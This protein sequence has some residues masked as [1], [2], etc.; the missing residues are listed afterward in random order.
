MFLSST[1]PVADAPR[2]TGCHRPM[3]PCF[4]A[5]GGMTVNAWYCR[6]CHCWEAAVGRERLITKSY[7]DNKSDRR[8]PGHG[9]AKNNNRGGVGC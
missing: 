6:A 1:S 7:W 2:C 5:D 8:T 3:E 9:Q 4:H